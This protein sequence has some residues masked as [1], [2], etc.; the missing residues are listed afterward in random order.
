M[1]TILKSLLIVALLTAPLVQVYAAGGAEGHGGEVIDIDKRP[2]LRDLVDKTACAWVSATD[3]GVKMPRFGKILESIDKVHWYLAYVFNDEMKRL[4]VCETRSPLKQIPDDDQDGL[5]IYEVDTRQA[6]IRLN[7]MIFIDANIFKALSEEDR[8]YLLL[9][10]V[11]HSFIPLDAKR[12]P[13]KVRNFV[14][15]V[16]QHE[17]SAMSKEQFA[18]QVTKN[19]IQVTP[20]TPDSL[21]E[22]SQANLLTALNE[23]RSR[24]ERE[25]AA[26]WVIQNLDIGYLKDAHKDQLKSLYEP[27]FTSMVAAIQN[28][29]VKRTMKLLE[30]GV[31][32]N[33]RVTKSSVMASSLLNYAIELGHRPIVDLLLEQPTINVNATGDIKF[34]GKIISNLPTIAFASYRDDIELAKRLVARPELD[35][36]AKVGTRYIAT[37]IGTEMSFG[38]MTALHLARSPE[39]VNVL[40]S[41]KEIDANALALSKTPLMSYCAKAGGSEI[42]GGSDYAKI[43]RL[44]LQSRDADPNI[45]VGVSALAYGISSKNLNCV[46]ALTRDPR[47]DPNLGKTFSKQTPL[48]LLVE[49]Y[50]TDLRESDGLVEKMLY[51]LVLD[52]RTDLSARN[53]EGLTALEL[54][55]K[56]AQLG[57]PYADSFVIAFESAIKQRNGVKNPQR[58]QPTPQPKPRRSGN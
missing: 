37:V 30:H 58:P 40:L 29:D 22:K 33:L 46:E 1:S 36:N 19:D 17:K 21:D 7:D 15:G 44:L 52:Q 42:G 4:S 28:G 49:K 32:P 48:H 26:L 16:A 54:I 8:A 25:Q 23:S 39:M 41:R 53:A 5:T 45:V 18:L 50:A 10:E 31:S 3:F 51:V 14:Y 56:Q 9:H 20:R 35:I 38:E 57:F 24:F 43:R 6:A 2:R 13:S 27:L 47:L 11:T 34:E 12:R 55:Q